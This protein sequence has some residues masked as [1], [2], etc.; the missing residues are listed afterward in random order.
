MIEFTKPL[1]YEE[2]NTLALYPHSEQPIALIRTGQDPTLAEMMEDIIWATENMAPSMVAFEIDPTYLGDDEYVSIF[3][4][5]TSRG[6]EVKNGSIK[7]TVNV[8]PFDESSVKAVKYGDEVL[9]VA[10]LDGYEADEK[11]GYKSAGIPSYGEVGVAGLE[12]LRA[13]NPTNWTAIAIAAGSLL[14]AI[15]IAAKGN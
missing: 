9:A 11:Y 14:L 5:L 10:D 15:T 13:Y 8:E 2:R 6:F 1:S 4:F 3:Q 7:N 12:P